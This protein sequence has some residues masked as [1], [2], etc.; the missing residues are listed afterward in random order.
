[1][2]PK[3]HDADRIRTSLRA[4]GAFA[5]IAAKVNQQSKPYL[6]TWLYSE[7]NLIEGFV[8]KLKYFKHVATRHDRLTENFLAMVQLAPMRLWLRAH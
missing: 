3:A 8:S 2:A 7:H 4:R 6:G 1:L 5:N